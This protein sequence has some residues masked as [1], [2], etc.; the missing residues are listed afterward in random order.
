MRRREFIAFMVSWF[1]E[2][3]R[4]APTSTVDGLA[5]LLSGMATK[6]FYGRHWS[7]AHGYTLLDRNVHHKQAESRLGADLCDVPAADCAAGAI[8]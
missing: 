5:K 8:S 7:A 4:L 1:P 6:Y 2:N 3:D